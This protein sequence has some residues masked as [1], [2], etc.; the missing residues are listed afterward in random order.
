MPKVQGITKASLWESWKNVRKQLSRTFL[1]DVTDF[2]EFDIDPEWWIKRLLADIEAGRYEPATVHRFSVAKK[3]GFSRRMTMPSVPDLVL[4]RAVVDYLY[5]KSKR[6]EQPHVYFAQNTLS[7]KLKQIAKDGEGGDPA[8][9]FAS[10]SALVAWLKYDQYRKH[11]LMQQVHPYIVLTDIT[12][13]FD[14]VLY[15]RVAD[16][17]H[18]IRVDRNLVGLLFFILE[19]LSIRDA[20]NESPRIGLPVDDFDCSRTIAHMVLF[21]HDDRMAQH[22]GVNAY[23]R[24][25]DDQNFG[26]RSYSEGL[27]IL[28]HCGDSLARLHLTPNAAKTRI[29]SLA[30]ASRHFY[31]DINAELDVIDKMARGTV[32]EKRAFRSALGQVWRK[33][34]K[35]EMSGGEWGK[36][37]KRFYRLAG[38]ATARFLRHRA[39]PDILAE[40]TL[41]DRIADYMRVTGSADQYLKFVLRLWADPCQVY[42]D[43]NQI[44]TEGLLKIEATSVEAG[45]IRRIASGLLSGKYEIPGWQRCAA[46]APLLILRYGDRRSLPLL[47]RLVGSLESVAHPAIA[48]AVVAVYASYGDGEY[49][50]AEKAASQLRDNHLAQFLRMLAISRQYQTVPERFKIRRE[51]IYDSVAGKK[52][53]DTRKLLVLRLLR[54]NKKKTVLAWVQ[55]TRDWMV[56]QD[57]PDFD[58]RLVVRLLT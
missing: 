26:A 21:P 24:W 29:L 34:R 14:T 25:M 6:V 7:K 10:G 27:N 55:S 32:A 5:K 52:R 8:Y 4:Y 19:R 37:L 42:P 18:A 22:V 31:F 30:E 11:L 36:V 54:L 23:V 9:A 16:A 12:N 53:V 50:E 13:F 28:K 51:P 44:L 39:L 49:R 57:V 40:P 1:R 15:D 41:T 46:L 56:K 3:M 48:K 45:A 35:F 2:V 33:Y 47:K 58:K 17:L 20:F 43:V 38:V